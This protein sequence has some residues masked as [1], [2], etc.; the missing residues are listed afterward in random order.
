MERHAK[1]KEICKKAFV[2]VGVPLIVA[3]L[4][5]PVFTYD[6]EPQAAAGACKN[7]S[8]LSRLIQTVFT[9]RS[10]LLFPSKVI[11]KNVLV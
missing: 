11:R 2:L 7:T 5:V 8:N 3:A 4:L 9:G 6:P 1:N 10:P